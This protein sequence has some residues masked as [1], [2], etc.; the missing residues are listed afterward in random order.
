MLLYDR[1]PRRFLGIRKNIWGSFLFLL[2]GLG[3]G[4]TLSVSIG[5]L[6]VDPFEAFL[7][8]FWFCVAGYGWDT[9]EGVSAKLRLKFQA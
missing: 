5:E 8:F 7:F 9:L 6:P 4:H 1:R 2:G 3:V